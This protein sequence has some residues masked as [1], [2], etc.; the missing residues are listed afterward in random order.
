MGLSSLG[1]AGRVGWQ[2]VRSEQDLALQH[3]HVPLQSC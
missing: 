2:E 3:A 1:D